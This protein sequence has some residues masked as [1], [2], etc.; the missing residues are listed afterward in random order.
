[1]DKTDDPSDFFVEIRISEIRRIRDV[2]A[3]LP[4]R[5]TSNLVRNRL[6]QVIDLSNKLLA[7]KASVTP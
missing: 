7:Q 6:R 2:L 1:M 4:E 3:R 5:H